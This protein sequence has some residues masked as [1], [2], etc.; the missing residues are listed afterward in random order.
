MFELDR[1]FCQRNA[2]TGLMEWFFNAREGTFGPFE[3]KKIALSELKVFTDRRQVTDDDGGRSKVKK[4]NSLSL[5]P[6]TQL[7]LEPIGFDHTK[8]KKG[9]DE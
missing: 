2:G 7:A 4:K 1:T 9:V 5:A 8:R 3:N 6:M